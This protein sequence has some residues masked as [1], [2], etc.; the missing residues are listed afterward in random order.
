M[1]Q[2]QQNRFVL[3]PSLPD[4]TR[5][6]IAFPSPYGVS[7]I[8]GDLLVSTYGTGKVTRLAGLTASAK[9]VTTFPA[10]ID[11]MVWTGRYF[12]MVTANVVR[13]FDGFDPAKLV[14]SFTMANMGI[15]WDGMNLMSVT[16]SGLVRFHRNEAT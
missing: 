9:G 4:T 2:L 7:V 3:F 15:G 14:R 10:S 5:Q 13:V 6:E 1:T 12:V 11:S 16:A 8:E